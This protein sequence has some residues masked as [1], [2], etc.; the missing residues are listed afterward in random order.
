MIV[1]FPRREEAELV[2]MI[3]PPLEAD[4][5]LVKTHYSG[6]S[7][8]TDRAVYQ[9]NYP[10]RPIEYPVAPG[11]MLTG[12]VVA[13][14]PGQ[15]PFNDGD[16]VFVWPGFDR[17]R[18]ETTGVVFPS[19]IPFQAVCGGHASHGRDCPSYVRRRTQLRP[20]NRRGQRCELGGQRVCSGSSGYR[21]WPTR[22]GRDR[23]C[24]RRCNPSRV[25]PQG[26]ASQAPARCHA[27]RLSRSGRCS[28]AHMPGGRM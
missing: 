14:G 16:M 24:G 3:L 18:R 12:Q 17:G 22:R 20:I 26:R 13:K 28:R 9:D 21:G 27:H 2:D 8:G 7:M 5:V 19:D 10:G 11:Y 6:I 1:I 23:R 25:P 15:H 4:Q